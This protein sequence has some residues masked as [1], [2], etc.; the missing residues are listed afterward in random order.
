MIKNI[1]TIR[2]AKNEKELDF[3]A[4]L[5]AAIGFAPATS[6]KTSRGHGVPF[7]VPVGKLEFVAGEEPTIS[8][9]FGDMVRLGVNNVNGVKGV[10]IVFELLKEVNDEGGITSIVSFISSLSSIINPPSS[11]I[12]SSGISMITIISF[13]S[14]SSSFKYSRGV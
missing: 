3:L 5:F 7:E 4:S 14:S 2:K 9:G 10:K 12:G 6:W 1:T 13:N 11:M 8:A